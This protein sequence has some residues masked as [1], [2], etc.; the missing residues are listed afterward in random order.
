MCSILARRGT[1]ADAPRRQRSQNR[2]RAVPRRLV[3]PAGEHA[4]FGAPD[5]PRADGHVDCCHRSCSKQHLRIGIPC[6]CVHL[7]NTCATQSRGPD[8]CVLSSILYAPS[9]TAPFHATNLGRLEAAAWKGGGVHHSH[10]HRGPK[11]QFCARCPRNCGSY[12]RN[13]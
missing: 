1:S 12:A 5:R 3:G 7:S 10:G 9:Q 13:C 4:C 6:V 11:G 8:L 2:A